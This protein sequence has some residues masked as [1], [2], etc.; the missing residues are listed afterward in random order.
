MTHRS[1]IGSAQA[2]AS[3]GTVTHYLVHAADDRHL[4]VTRADADAGPWHLLHDAPCPVRRT[5]F[6]QISLHPTHLSTATEGPTTS[7][8]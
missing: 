2:T 1:T 5:E 3:D 4:Q 8:R 6:S 7:C